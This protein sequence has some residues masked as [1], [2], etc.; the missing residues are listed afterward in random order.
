MTK[1]STQRQKVMAAILGVVCVA[2]LIN[3]LRSPYIAGGPS[4]PSRP[5]SPRVGAHAPRTAASNVVSELSRYEPEVQLE[6]LRQLNLR[7][8]PA[9]DRNPFVYGPTPAEIEQ[10]KRTAENAKN[11]PPPA[12]PPPPPITVKALGFEQ[13]PG[14]LRKAFFTDAADTPEAP[15][16]TYQATV[17]QSF[18]DHYK[19]LEIT[20]TAVTIE[21]Q[22]SHVKAQLPFPD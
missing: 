21:D 9:M 1:M 14:D 5:A 20:S 12:P 22:A 18:A 19:V 16:Q 15:A 13:G 11:P 17:G 6:T 4:G 2:L 3:L 8:I 10:T 7:Q